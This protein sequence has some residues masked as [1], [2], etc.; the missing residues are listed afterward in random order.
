MNL[1]KRARDLTQADHNGA[2][3]VERTRTQIKHEIAPGR[4]WLH[5]HV[6]PIHINGTE[7]EIDTEWI[8]ADQVADAPWLR[9]MVLADYNA[10]AL[11]GTAAFDAGQIVRYVDPDSGE[12]LTFQPQQL[13][14]TNDLDQIEAI[15]DPQTVGA[16]IS[17][18][19]LLWSG[20]FGLGLDFEWKTDT[21][22]LIKRLII[23]SGASIG[24]PPQFII[25]GGNPVLRLQFIFQKSNNVDIWIDGAL[26]DEKS[27]NP[28][29]TSAPVEF[30]DA[31]NNVLWYFAP[32]YATDSSTD[33]DVA[34]EITPEYRFRSQ[35]NNLFVE[36]RVPWSWLETAVYPVTID[37]TVNPQTAAGTDDAH[38]DHTGANFSSSDTII[39]CAANT[40]AAS[41]RRY[42]GAF[43]VQVSASGTVNQ[44]YIT[45]KASSTSAD[46][47][48]VDLSCEDVDS[49]DDFSTT[50]DVT[51]R[52][53]TT[54]TTVWVTTGIGTGATNSADF[55]SSVQEIFDR[56]GWSSGNYI[57]CFMDGRGDVSQAFAPTSYDGTAG[58]APLL[59]VDYTAAG[60]TVV[61]D[62]ISSGLIPFAR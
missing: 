45:V 49:A 1:A 39:K 17:D 27:N 58:D 35:A 46:D 2:A 12:D 41:N 36:V 26:W 56:G 43:R 62:I 30:R 50:P 4:F 54:A 61:Q 23:A 20:A 7:T 13:Q 3:V 60:G 51:S 25:D 15:G 29:T 5:S 22:R 19:S 33:P 24:T 8:L 59:F 55:D 14:W 9:K 18:D 44:A 31:S 38:E 10:Y 11:P 6:S 16:T 47:P 42:F 52:V 40:S 21:I 37:P 32:A 57:V 28:L 48:N 34:Q 53:R